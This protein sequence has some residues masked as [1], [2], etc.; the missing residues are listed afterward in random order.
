MVSLLQKIKV[1]Y[2][3]WYG[4][5]Q[6]LTKLHKYS[7]GHRIDTLFV[8]IMEAVSIASFLPKEDREKRP[9]IC[10]AIRKLDTLKVLLIVLWEVKSVD[11]KKYE[12]LSIHLDEIGKMLGG[13]NGQLSK[14][15]SPA[16]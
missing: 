11:N 5:Y 1:V 13:W 14:Q 12:T 9:Y 16:K 4:Y 15:N 3:L 10:I 8:E 7:L 2:V 6:N